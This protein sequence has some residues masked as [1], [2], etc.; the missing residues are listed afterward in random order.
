[1]NYL[2]CGG[3]YSYRWKIQYDPFKFNILSDSSVF[4]LSMFFLLKDGASDKQEQGASSSKP[5]TK[6][7]SVDLPILASTTRQLDKDVLTNFVE[8]EVS[9]RFSL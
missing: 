5:K 4:G 1:M 9:S 7:K 3:S 8:Y 6:V 2:F